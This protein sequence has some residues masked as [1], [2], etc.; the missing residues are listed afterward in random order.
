MLLFSAPLSRTEDVFGQPS[1][2]SVKIP[3]VVVYSLL[4]GENI[5]SRFNISRIIG[6]RERYIQNHHAHYHFVQ[7][8]L[9]YNVGHPVWQK[10]EDAMDLVKNY[11][12][13]WFLD[14]TDAFIMNGDISI[15]DIVTEAK[16]M[17]PGKTIDIIVSYDCTMINCGSFFISGSKWSQDMV[18]YWWALGK[19]NQI[20]G[21]YRDARLRE[22]EA[23]NYII[24]SNFMDAKNHTAILP[25]RMINSY[26]GNT[27]GDLYE[28]GDFVIH[29]PNN[30]PRRLSLVMKAMNLKE[31]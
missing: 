7:R 29:E 15:H 16:I 5:E 13:V 10:V 30:G 25:Q 28:L 27:C 14:A 21:G 31:F 22:Q 6:N 4:A 19:Y 18:R 20:Q 11:D 9:S 24:E 26:A 8:N 1:K 12:W 3:K 17:N 23:L 2:V